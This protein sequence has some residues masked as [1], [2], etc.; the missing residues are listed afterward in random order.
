MPGFQRRIAALIGLG[1]AL[2][3]GLRAGASMAVSPQ[4][5]SAGG[6]WLGLGE[7]LRLAEQAS[8]GLEAASAR[9][10][11]ARAAAGVAAAFYYPRVVAAAGTGTGL[12]GSPGLAPPGVAGV[13]GSPYRSGPTV[14]AD[15]A[16]YWDLLDVG[17]ML[18]HS[19][20]RADRVSAA[21]Q[22]ALTRVQVDQQALLEYFD[23][24]RQQGRADV[25][26][27]AVTRVAQVYAVVR[28]D[29]AI[30]RYTEVQLLL[31]RESLQ[32]ASLAAALARER[33]GLARQDLAITLGRDGRALDLPPAQAC[34]VASLDALS[35]GAA[36]PLLRVA[37]SLLKAAQARQDAALARA[38]PRVYGNASLGTVEN[39]LLV[40]TKDYSASL[41]VELPLFQG[42]QVAQGYRQAG[43]A[44]RE[45]MALVEDAQ[46]QVDRANDGF[47][48]AVAEARLR[49]DSLRSRQAA[50]Q[51]NFVLSKE[52]YFHLLGQFTDMLQAL[53]NVD[54]I[55]TQLDDAQ[56]DLCSSLGAQRLFNGAILAP[57]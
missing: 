8:P 22:A 18:G 54:N 23:A 7:A 50:A 57:P 56:V 44:V 25:M 42:F 13:L 20:A 55:D 3:A 33:A 10:D 32:Q 46:R 27:L 21:D 28:R 36:N 11:Q 12:A 51:R 9:Q 39:T 47:D 45:R 29:E 53:Q 49:L 15:V 16:A 41:G 4:A 17:E 37:R 40:P 30:G 52:R 31:L 6:A 24:V 43:A 14:G 5:G 34:T 1:L 26:A 19:A 38:L 35:P 48:E 2:A